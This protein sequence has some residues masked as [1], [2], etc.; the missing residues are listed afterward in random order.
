MTNGS[1]GRSDDFIGGCEVPLVVGWNLFI[2]LNAISI[3]LCLWKT[4]IIIISSH[5]LSYHDIWYNMSHCVTHRKRT[6]QMISALIGDSPIGGFVFGSPITNGSVGNLP[7]TG[8]T[9]NLNRAN[10][11]WLFGDPYH[12]NLLYI[13]N[14]MI[15]TS[16]LHSKYVHMF[17]RRY[18]CREN[19]CIYSYNVNV[20]SPRSC[21]TIR[22]EV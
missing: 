6:K 13:V 20:N 8:S 1:G 14:Q 5:I 7:R 11:H 2:P 16:H 9:T 15:Y 12:L 17:V 10:S 4:S 21:K 3:A 18:V 22:S 19:I